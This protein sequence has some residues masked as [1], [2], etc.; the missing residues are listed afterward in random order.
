MKRLLLILLLAFAAP[1]EA[2]VCTGTG[3]CTVTVVSIG[4]RR[5]KLGITAAPGVNVRRSE[6]PR[7]PRA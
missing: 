7:E 1:A 2:I 4:E 3:P 5:V 6:L